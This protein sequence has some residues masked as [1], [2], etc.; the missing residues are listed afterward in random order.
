MID[1]ERVNEIFLDCFYTKDEFE[2]LN[3]IPE[4]AVIVEGI[5]P[6]RK[7]GFHPGRLESHREEVRGFLDQLP[8][9]FHEGT[10]DGWSFLNACETKDGEQW[11]GLHQRMEQLFC[12]GIGL[13]IAKY[14]MPSEMWKMLPGGM[15]YITVLKEK[16]GVAEDDK[17]DD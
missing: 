3:E 9:P 12:L 10:G 16:A 1:P 8:E 13:G 2:D 5:A 11:T 4:D 6:N 17:S 14:L 15:P 7:F